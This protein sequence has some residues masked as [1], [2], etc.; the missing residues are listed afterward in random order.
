MKPERLVSAD[1]VNLSRF[2]IE[3]SIEW[4]REGKGL[5]YLCMDSEVAP[6][7]E[8]VLILKYYQKVL[9]KKLFEKGKSQ[10]FGNKPVNPIIPAKH[11]D[12]NDCKI[13]TA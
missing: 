10:S 9:K 2:Q 13:S 1:W 4:A 8:P 11:L 12:M 3:W 6:K 7:S 5:R